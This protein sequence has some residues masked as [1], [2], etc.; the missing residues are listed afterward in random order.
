MAR[1][2]GEF[3]K[4]VDPNKQERA[5]RGQLGALMNIRGEGGAAPEARMADLQ[6]PAAAAEGPEFEQKKQQNRA[7]LQDPRTQAAL[8]NFA[9]GIMQPLGSGAGAGDFI[10]LL[11]SSMGN[12]MGAAA[13]VD[14]AM[15]EAQIAAQEQARKDAELGLKFRAEDRAERQFERTE[16]RLDRAEQI[17]LRKLQTA[18]RT[19]KLTAAQEARKIELQEKQIG[20]SADRLAMDQENTDRELGLNERKFETEATK[21][22]AEAEKI[23]AETEAIRSGR[24]GEVSNIAKLQRDRQAALDDKR[25]RDAA[26]IQ[27]QIDDIT[28]AGATASGVET[29]VGPDGQLQQ[30]PIPGGKAEAEIDAQ[31]E[32]AAAQKRIQQAQY[33]AAQANITDAIQMLETPQEIIGIEI[34]ADMH[35]TGIGSIAKMVPGTPAA[36]LAK[37]LDSIGARLQ[38]NELQAMREASPTGGTG[39]GAVSNFEGM[40]VREAYYSLYQGQTAAQLKQNLKRF[41]TLLDDIVGGGQLSTINQQIEAGQL[42]PEAAEQKVNSIFGAPNSANVTPAEP[43]YDPAVAPPWADQELKELWSRIPEAHRQRMWKEGISK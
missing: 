7:W 35:L 26:E 14:Q 11:G 29:F 22:A 41:Q 33:N 42:T 10:G 39:L 40:T 19:A 23:K 18:E 4:G 15:T 20:V 43:G 37:M 3:Y 28:T 12:A 25:Y 16:N 5:P 38:L 31:K 8:A 32:A 34:P 27:R 21:T 36:D 2:R 30:R 17:E 24:T 6:R 9:M 13:E 1:D